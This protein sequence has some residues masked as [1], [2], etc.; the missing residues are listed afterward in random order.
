MAHAHPD[1]PDSNP[2]A[3][4]EHAE[5]TG[6]AASAPR[7]R[8]DEAV[9]INLIHE[10]LRTS[11]SLDELLD[12]IVIML[13]SRASLG[14]SRA[15]IFRW[16]ESAQLFRGHGFFAAEDAETHAA[17][18]RQIEQQFHKLLKQNGAGDPTTGRSPNPPGG[19]YGHTPQQLQETSDW[20]EVLQRLRPERAEVREIVAMTLR[21]ASGSAQRSAASGSGNSTPSA[22]SPSAQ[23]P[24][25]LDLLEPNHCRVLSHQDLRSVQLPKQIPSIFSGDSLWIQVATQQGP[26]L[27]VAVDKIHESRPI[28]DADCLHLNWFAG[29]AA[30]AMENLELIANLR[31]NNELLKE[32]DKLKST[33][34]ATISHE[35]RTPLTAI[36]GFTR[37]VLDDRTGPISGAQRDI[38]GRV[39]AHADRL[40][41]VVNDLIE[42]VEIDSGAALSLAPEP[43]DP[44]DMLQE[45]L[46]KLEPRRASKQATIQPVVSGPIPKILADPKGLRR[47]F[48]HL[49]D[50]ALKF[51]REGGLVKIRFKDQ[52]NDLAIEIRDYGIGI[53]QDRLQAI[54]DAFYQVDGQLARE[55]E[56]MGIG[57]T[58]T[59][60]LITGA[61]GRL[62][63]ESEQ[64]KGSRFTIIFP[65]MASGGDAG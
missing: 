16:D 3:T 26:R 27:I 4:S 65:R 39:L 11:R 63:V 61:G 42:I 37:L 7:H 32:L 15:L 34:L 2:A 57:L 48:Y 29:Q 56:G 18:Q 13:L 60:K 43:V 54:F 49:L 23:A 31:R 12:S 22:S 64:G 30:L 28:D 52:E 46:P 21:P 35:L 55:Y 47:I 41:D 50:N 36:T 25:L 1:R 19:V 38:L 10:A 45:V 62:E 40:A 44:L 20:I 17:V 58:L 5:A 51:S 24:G 8:V 59:R 9:T 14:F 33:F 53:P 6:T